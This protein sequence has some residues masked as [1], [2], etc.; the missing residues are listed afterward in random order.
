MGPRHFWRAVYSDGTSIDGTTHKYPD[1]DR[2]RLTQF[3]MVD[4][5]NG[6]SIVVLHLRQGM[7][8]IYRMRN[9]LDF[10]GNVKGRIQLVGWHENKGGANVQLVMV[11]FEDNHIEVLDRWRDDFAPYSKP[12]LEEYEK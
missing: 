10:Y 12:I 6:K 5:L 11:L 3:H 1:I 2:S 9:F 4:K 8:L 7:K